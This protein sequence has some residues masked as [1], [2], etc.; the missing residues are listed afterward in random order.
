MR[1]RIKR[2]KERLRSLERQIRSLTKRTC[3]RRRVAGREVRSRAGIATL[4][5]VPV[6]T[7]RGVLCAPLS[8]DEL[9]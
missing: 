2:E 8:S 9:S 6:N 1:R 5:K 7:V 4:G 3:L